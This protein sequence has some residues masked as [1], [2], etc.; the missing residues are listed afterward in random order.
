[1]RPLRG[2][3]WCW[4]HD[5]DKAGDRVAARL[6]GGQNRRTPSRSASMAP[7]SLRTVDEIQQGIDHV[8]LD[9]LEQENSAQRSRT[10]VAILTAAL[11]VLDKERFEERLAALEQAAGQNWRRAA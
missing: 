9:T 8:W 5:P 2:S 6:K 7:P 1:M 11:N 4:T 3:E 10:L